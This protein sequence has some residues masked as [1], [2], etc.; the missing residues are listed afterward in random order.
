MLSLRKTM[1]AAAL[2]AL[3]GLAYAQDW[4]RIDTQ[5]AFVSAVD[6]KTLQNA[7]G[8]A[9]IN[10]DGTGSGRTE[11]GRYALN[12]VWDSG[13]YCRNFRFAGQ[14]ATGTLCA[15]IDIAGNQIRFTNQGGNNSVSVWS[16]R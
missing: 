3:P 10:G 2:T 13:R 16:I 4:Q 5:A 12:W 9:K 14:D 8:T 6:G 15:L 1:I 11:N 7:G